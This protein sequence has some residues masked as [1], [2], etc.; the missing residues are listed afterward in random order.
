MLRRLA[1]VLLLALPLCADQVEVLAIGDSLTEEYAFEVP[2]SAPASDSGNANIR[3]WPELFR[4]FRVGEASL[5]TYEGTAGAYFPDLRNAGHKWN[6]GVPSFTTLDWYQV[7]TSDP[8]EVVYYATRSSLNNLLYQVDVVVIFLGGN[9]LKNDYNDIYSGTEPVNFYTG[10]HNRLLFVYNYVRAHPIGA[11]IPIVVCTIPDVSATPNIYQ[12]YNDPTLAANARTKIAALN[13]DIIDTFSPLANTAVARVDHITDLVFDLDP[14]HLNGTL[15]TIE[16]DPENPPDHLF[17]RDSFHP[18]T[19][20]QALIAN[21]LIAAINSL[22]LG[23]VTPF[24]HREILDNLL[25]LDPDQPFLDWIAASTVPGTGM[26]DD[27]DLDGLPSVVEMGLGTPPGA[28]STPIIGNWR[29]GLSWT[30]DPVALRYLDLFAEESGDLFSW[31][32]VPAGRIAESSGTLTATPP[33]G[34][35]RSFVRLHAE[36][37][38]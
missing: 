38:P 15:F 26:D 31:S 8:S 21:E 20:A 16:G 23:P 1:V 13:Q 35:A 14:F 34:E 37:R 12:V 9:D 33:P 7:L 19:A 32:A 36:P 22:G 27:P 4:I 17:A 30:P 3:N 11:G 18:A 10:I 28:F 29:D 25:G 2:F 5:G 24:S 6:F